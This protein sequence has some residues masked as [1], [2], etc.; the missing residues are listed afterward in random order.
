MTRPATARFRSARDPRGLAG[1][2]VYGPLWM[3]CRTLGVA[4]FG[5]RV[6]FAE[7]LP[8]RGGLL[9]LSNHQSHL[10]PMLVGL[11]MDRRLSSLARS[12]LYRFKP[13]GA[14]ITALDAVPID[15]EASTV[16]AMKAVIRRLEDG[17]AVVIFPEGTR[18]SDG[19]MADFKHGFTVIARRAGVPI[20]PVAVVGAYECWPR[21]RLLPRPGRVRLEFGR[22]M[23]PDEIA[24]L[25]DRQLVAECERRIRELDA[26]GRRMLA[27][28]RAP[29]AEA[30]PV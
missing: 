1:R 11:A 17:A 29:A 15:R 21:T 7:P 26:V 25:D 16:A 27:G 5:V 4:L 6:R 28:I 12:S 9:V 14:L 23:P 8:D 20:V 13:F 3:L 10:D 24:R 22:L 30:G 2:C 18:S 19:R